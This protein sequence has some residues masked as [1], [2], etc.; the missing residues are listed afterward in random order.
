[1][2]KMIPISISIDEKQLEKILKKVDGMALK[3]NSNRSAILR[4]VLLEGF[5]MTSKPIRP[6]N[7]VRSMSSKIVE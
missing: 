1:M 7:Y 2:S 3:Q 5:G 6:R 4:N